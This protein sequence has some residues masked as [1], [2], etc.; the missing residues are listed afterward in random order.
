MQLVGVYSSFVISV[1]IG[2]YVVAVKTGVPVEQTA[3]LL[4]YTFL[5]PYFMSSLAMLVTNVMVYFTSL[6][7]VREFELLP[8]EPPH[9]LL[10]DARLGDWPAAGGITLSGLSLQYSA[11]T[12]TV[13]KKLSVEFKPGE[14]IGVV[15]RTGAGKSSLMSV[16]FRL[17]N[18]TGGQVLIDGVDTQTVGL[19]RLREKITIIP[20]EPILMSGTARYNLD[21]FGA[22]GETELLRAMEHAQLAPALLDVDVDLA[23]EGLS[24]GQRQL[25]CF[26][27]AILHR[28]PIL[29]MDEPTAN[30]D[31]ATDTLIQSM[32][33]TQFADTTVI[34]IAHRLSTIIDYDRILVMGDGA[35]LEYGPAHELLADPSGHLSHMVASMGSG[36]EG[37]LRESVGISAAK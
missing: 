25:L 16:I 24:M 8:Q 23:G 6:E 36:A 27:R 31:L 11:D 18:P 19:R 35:V 10:A 17:V 20:Q 12:A 32:V 28:T 33:R 30:C 15:G 4:T 1:T 5:I 34:T 29:L 7:R 2:A 3:L 14:S 37:K 21:P 26:A 22:K 13:L 9:T